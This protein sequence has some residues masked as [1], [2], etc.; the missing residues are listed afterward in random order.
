MDNVSKSFSAENPV[1]ME[2]TIWLV[3]ST[4]VAGNIAWCHLTSV[5][6]WSMRQRV[7]LVAQGDARKSVDT[8]I[9]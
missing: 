9:V 3:N 7:L 4:P 8:S 2:M 1:V 6:G 5:D